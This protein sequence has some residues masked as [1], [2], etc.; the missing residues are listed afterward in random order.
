MIENTKINDVQ[1]TEGRQY[2]SFLPG[3][4]QVQI[5]MED[6]AKFQ[7]MLSLGIK[8]RQTF[9]NYQRGRV[10]ITPVEKEKIESIL[11]DCGA[12]DPI[13]QKQK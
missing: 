4:N 2:L 13:W 11:R 9:Y 3:W 7:I 1:E 6:Q 12:K 5:G 8:N 10:R